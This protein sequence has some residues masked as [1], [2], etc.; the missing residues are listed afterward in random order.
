MFKGWNRAR[1]ATKVG[2]LGAALLCIALASIGLT[3]WIG[4]QLEGGAAAV[5]EAGRLRMQTW[6]LAHQGAAGASGQM[7]GL[8]QAYDASLQLLVDGDPARPLFLPRDEPTLQAYRSVREGWL[9]LRSAAPGGLPA[10]TGAQA[11]ALVR[12]IDILVD[13]VEARMGSWSALLSSVQLA[14]VGLAIA[15]AMIFLYSSHLVVFAPVDR[16]RRGLRALEQGTLGARI[17][18]DSLD[19]FGDLARGFNRMAQRLEAV[20]CGM[21]DEV[22]AKTA[23][24]RLEQQRLATLYEAT[25]FAAGASSSR[26]LATGFADR[27]RRAAGADAVALRWMDPSQQRMVLLAAQGL[28]PA[29]LDTER[30]LA[31]GECH[32]GSA[33]LHASV[34]PITSEHRHGSHCAKAG[35]VAVTA[36]ALTTQ[37]RVMGEVDLLFR[38][39][40][41]PSK[42]DRELLDSLASHLAS[43]MDSLR[44]AALQREAAVAE[45][46]GMLARELHD[47]IA[48]SL[49]FMKIQL[50]LLKDA[51]QGG[52]PDAAARLVEE[53][54]LGL[55]EC[56]ADVRALLMHFRTRTDG[57]DMLPALQQ[58]LQ[59]FRLQSGLQAELEVDGHGAPLPADVQVQ[60]L[61][62]VQEALANVRKHAQARQ[63]QV[64]L[65][66]QPHWQIDVRD[67]GRGFDPAVDMPDDSHVGLRI[68]RERAAKVGAAVAFE[69]QPGRGTLVRVSLPESEAMN[70]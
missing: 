70:P 39:T 49:A 55:K 3:L 34:I 5:N 57:D 6:R 40:P 25:S 20:Y 8:A 15:A 29:M 68:M 21:A 14:L 43:A 22:R 7:R 12:R 59:K 2:I 31:P 56:T 53:L 4:W 60:L 1:L 36:V 42:A 50:Q 46:R 26:D 23:D 38:E 44:N 28:P 13:A 51:R 17:A 58:T 18:E 47:S 41:Q 48:Q 27:M 62:V 9:Q 45:E 66:H 54:E 64:R 33:G 24:L 19:E 67:D 37:G 35:F 61:H 10:P 11:E 32:C 30:C 52:Q 69:S 16:L 63:V 65:T